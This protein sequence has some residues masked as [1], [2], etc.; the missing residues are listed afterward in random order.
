MEKKY[1]DKIENV[2]PSWTKDM[3]MRYLLNSL[4]PYFTGDLNYYLASPE[5]QQ[6]MYEEGFKL[7]GPE[8]VCKSISE[9]YVDLFNQF[10]INAEVTPGTNAN[11]PLYCIVAE[12]DTG[13]IY[14]S[15]SGD[16]FREQYGL[17]PMCFANMKSWCSNLI[18]KNHPS[19]MNLDQKYIEEIDQ[20]LG[21]EYID[22][23]ISEIR[24]NSI[25]NGEYKKYARLPKDISDEEVLLSKVDLLNEK[26]INIGN[27][28]GTYERY[29]VY[30]YILGNVYN[31][32]EIKKVS[33]SIDTKDSNKL[34]FQLNGEREVYRFAETYTEE[35]GYKLEKRMDVSRKM[36]K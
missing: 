1:L 11:V 9:Y 6:R 35:T 29:Q 21:I 24:K 7:A 33:T 26:L 15:P 13:W 18:L 36:Y 23:Y 8:I 22:G 3:K 19:V 16:L 17:K 32:Q 4:A 10:D 5:E 14:I 20:E 28:N 34:I 25:V 12:G 27:V 2:N 31:K 30:K